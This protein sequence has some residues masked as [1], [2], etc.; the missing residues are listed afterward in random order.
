MR[1]LRGTKMRNEISILFPV[2]ITEGGC[3]WTTKTWEIY[4]IY[5]YYNYQLVYKF[6]K[7]ID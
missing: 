2:G 3:P 4:I 1:Q 6:M 7:R 5:S